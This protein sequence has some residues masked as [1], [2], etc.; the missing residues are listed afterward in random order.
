MKIPTP[1]LIDALRVPIPRTWW[2][3]KV[4][5]NDAAKAEE[6]MREAALQLDWFLNKEK[7]KN[8]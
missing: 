1:N 3:G 4:S 8:D 7:K 5:A 6:L 2:D